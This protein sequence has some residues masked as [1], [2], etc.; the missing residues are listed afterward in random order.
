MIREGYAAGATGRSAAKREL[1]SVVG[2]EKGQTVMGDVNTVQVSI[3]I[4]LAVWEALMARSEGN[5]GPLLVEVLERWQDS[6]PSPNSSALMGIENPEPTI[7]V[8]VGDVLAMAEDGA[9]EPLA[10]FA[11]ASGIALD[12]E[13]VLVGD[14]DDISANKRAGNRP[15]GPPNPPVVP[16][17]PHEFA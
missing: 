12:G 8:L 13:T 7:E 6:L 11:A 5:P 3:G 9:T 2:I 1:C 17:K 10:D 16:N 14:G 15:P 4:P